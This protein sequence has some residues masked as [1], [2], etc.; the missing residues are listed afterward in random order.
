M[1]LFSTIA[2]FFFVNAAPTAQS[3]NP[4]RE[5]TVCRTD[6]QLCLEYCEKRYIGTTPW[7][8]IRVTPHCDFIYYPQ[9]FIPTCPKVKQCYI[10][11]VRLE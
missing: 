4:V 8:R 7:G 10:G 9:D 3:P 1:Q 5:T 6:K 11:G 2:L